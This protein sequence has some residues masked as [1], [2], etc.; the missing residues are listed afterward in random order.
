M[1]GLASF[2]NSEQ[3]LVVSAVSGAERHKLLRLAIAFQKSA[4]MSM[5]CY[6]A[7]CCKNNLYAL[8][9]HIKR[10]AMYQHCLCD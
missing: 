4:D 8:L 1:R 10:C 5:I 7:Q 3:K 9:K 6:I 2:Y